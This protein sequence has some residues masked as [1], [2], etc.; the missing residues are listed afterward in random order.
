MSTNVVIQTLC[1][2]RGISITTEKSWIYMSRF[3]QFHLYLHMS[4]QNMHYSMQY[5]V[6]LKQNVKTKLHYT[7]FNLRIPQFVP[8]LPSSAIGAD[9]YCR[10]SLRP[11]GHTSVHLSVPNDVTALTL[12]GF[13]WYQ[14]EIWWDD[15]QQHEAYCYLKWPCPANFCAFRGT[16][17][18]IGVDQVW[19]TTL[20][21]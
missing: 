15:A 21:L 6:V 8:F 7:T 3:L 20:P 19:G 5:R 12:L 10:R 2:I 18:M 1:I 13:R 14:P 17:S 11:A 16:F 9:G 4:I